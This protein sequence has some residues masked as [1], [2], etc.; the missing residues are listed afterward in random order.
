MKLCSL[1][2]GENQTGKLQWFMPELKVFKYTF[3]FGLSN[4][5]CSM[6]GCECCIS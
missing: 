4:K 3:G 2:C 5:F 6:L 1:E